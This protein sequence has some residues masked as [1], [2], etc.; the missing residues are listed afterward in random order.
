MKKYLIT[1]ALLMGL[2]LAAGCGK[3]THVQDNLVKEW[4]PKRVVILPYQLATVNKETNRAG[5]PLTGAVFRG[6]EI[7]PTARVVMDQILEKQLGKMIDFEIVNHAQSARVFDELNR[8]MPI[9]AALLQ[10]GQEL[11][12]DTIIIG[13]VYR[14]SQRVG[15]AMGVETP[16]S[17]AFDI[18]VFRVSDGAIL[19]RNSF[20]QTQTSLSENLLNA[21]QYL[22][23]GLYWFKVEEFADY[24]MEELLSQFPWKAV[25]E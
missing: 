7:I 23:R 3:P 14:L 10:A 22:G 25:K 16:A 24:G 19:W 11:E 20:D 5:S 4:Q 12:A 17:A 21:G 13:Y 6:G 8:R 1:P 15:E 2:L 18:T 9:K